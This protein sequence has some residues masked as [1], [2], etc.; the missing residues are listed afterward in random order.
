[1]AS[2]HCLHRYLGGIGGNQRIGRGTVG[3]STKS[4]SRQRSG[5][6]AELLRGVD[7]DDPG[8][9]VVAERRGENGPSRLPCWRRIPPSFLPTSRH[10]GRRPGRR[11]GRAGANDMGP[12]ATST[13]IHRSTSL[14][15]AS[16]LSGRPF[17]KSVAHGT[18]ASQ[19]WPTGTVRPRMTLL[20][21][22]RRP[23]AAGRGR[24]DERMSAAKRTEAVH[25]CAL[26]ASGP[27]QH[28]PLDQGH[29]EMKARPSNDRQKMAA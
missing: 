29:Q 14:V 27:R 26:T 18:G 28:L 6:V 21:A 17:T 1:M 8:R 22:T 16:P 10:P 3:T 11:A 5:E 4:T 9:G 19:L 7:V 15:S 2:A 23:G 20:A 13:A 25:Q 12:S 24:P